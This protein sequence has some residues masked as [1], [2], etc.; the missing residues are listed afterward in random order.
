MTDE[1]QNAVSKYIDSITLISKGIISYNLLRSQDLYVELRRINSKFQLPLDLDL[2]S[3]YTYYKMLEIKSFIKNNLLIV[4]IDVP[5]VNQLI[6]DLY[7]VHPLFTPHKNDSRLFSYVDP[8]NPYLLVSL[9]RTVYTTLNNLEECNQYLPNEWLCKEISTARRIDTPNCEMELFSKSTTEIPRSCSVKHLFAETE[10]WHRLSP[11]EWVF[12]LSKP[13]LLNILCKNKEPQEEVLN[14]IGI[15]QLDRDCHARSDHAILETQAISGNVNINTKIPL[16]DIT[17]DDCCIKLHENITVQAVPLRPIT[18]TNLDLNELNFAKHKLNQFEEILQ[19]QLN[20]PFL[21]KHPSWFTLILSAVA[22]ILFLIVSYKI[23]K[24]IGI[25]KLISKYLSC[26]NTHDSS[27]RSKSC[28]LALPC[29]NIY[30]QSYNNHQ[31]EVDEAVGY[32]AEME[33][34][35][36]T[37]SQSPG[38]LSGRR[39]TRSV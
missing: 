26:S 28:C 22:T 34:L 7:R 27:T 16:T 3:I 8:S 17:T 6:Y 39:S 4:V 10:I 35:T 9:S 23:L 19:D 32:N 18:L 38:K 1:I 36:T 37:F 11:L 29:V 24:W 14:K 31:T 12:I 20:K 25:S 13:T 21:M 30:N 15:L 33:Q 2:N 5:L